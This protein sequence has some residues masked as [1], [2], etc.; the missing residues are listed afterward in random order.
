MA[1]IKVNPAAP[2]P[3]PKPVPK[4][5]DIGNPALWIGL[6]ILGMGMIAYMIG[7]GLKGTFKKR[8]E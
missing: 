8:T 1:T 3:T 5:G 7:K 2:T 4:T 6:V